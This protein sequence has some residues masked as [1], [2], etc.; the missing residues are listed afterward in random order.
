MFIK[1]INSYHIHKTRKK[2]F[3]KHF[4]MD[5]S[6][7]QEKLEICWQKLRDTL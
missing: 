5:L 3:K 4:N 1:D 2:S 6:I 7:G